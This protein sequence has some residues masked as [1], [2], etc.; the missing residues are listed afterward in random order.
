LA[1]NCRFS[2]SPDGTK[3]VAFQDGPTEATGTMLVIDTSA[4]DALVTIPTGGVP[5]SGH[6]SWQRLAP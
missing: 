6:V 2:W 3:I 4:K 5:A 1:C